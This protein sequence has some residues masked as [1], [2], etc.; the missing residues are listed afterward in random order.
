MEFIKNYLNHEFINHDE[1]DV[2]DGL[3]FICNKCKVGIIF[4][5]TRNRYYIESSCSKMLFKNKDIYELNLT[6]N[7]IIIK[8]IIE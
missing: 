4:W 8:S 3:Y 5:Q 2:D 1:C 6:C 7:E